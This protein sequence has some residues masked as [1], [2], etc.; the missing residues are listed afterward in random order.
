MSRDSL[1]QAEVGAVFQLHIC[2]DGLAE[3]SGTPRIHPALPGFNRQQIL[4]LSVLT[5]CG[6]LEQE[7]E[8][9]VMS[10]SSG[11]CS[12]QVGAHVQVV[13]YAGAI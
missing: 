6:S 5:G 1:I 11:L 10:S 12:V 4:P 13:L 9:T 8:M 2:H 3:A 7:V